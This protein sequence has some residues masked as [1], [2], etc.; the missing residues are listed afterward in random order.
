MLAAA[1]CTVHVV[2]AFAGPHGWSHAAAVR[3]TARQTAAVYGVNWGGGIYV[4][5]VFVAAWWIE[6]LWWR[7]APERYFHRSPAITWTLR[8]FYLLI[9]FNALVV[10]A[11]AARRPLGAT[12]TAALV[13]LW[14]PKPAA[15]IVPRLRARREDDGARLA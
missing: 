7:A 2:L 6:G 8:A 1:L 13:W 3:E 12:L 10:F 9:V 15:G 11:A 5:Y 4:N 14:R